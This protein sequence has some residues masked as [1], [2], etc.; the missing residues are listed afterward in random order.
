[1]CLL[2]PAY[3]ADGR[4]CDAHISEQTGRCFS[5]DAALLQEVHSFLGGL[6]LFPQQSDLESLSGLN[7]DI[8]LNFF[9]F[10]SN[11]NE[12]NKS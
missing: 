5:L 8:F 10:T 12:V 9:S 7:F 1:M 3:H 2:S 4:S 11:T 6:H